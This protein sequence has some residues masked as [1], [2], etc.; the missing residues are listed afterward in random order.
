MS[1]QTTAKVM[2]VEDDQG[3]R[4]QL[5]WALSDYQVFLA[6]DR[7]SAL[8]LLRKEEPNVVILD[9]GLPP[10]RDGATE[11]LAVLRAVLAFRPT[12]KVI[13]ASGNEDRRNALE[14]ISLGAYDFYP[15]PVDQEV[16]KIIIDRAWNSHQLEEEVRHLRETESRAP[17]RGLIANSPEML[18]TCRM[19]ERVASSDVSVMITGESGTGKDVLANAIHQASA[20][21]SRPFVAINCAAIPENLLESELFGHEKGAFTGAIRQVIGKIEQADGGTLFLDEIGDMPV[22]LQAKLLRFLQDKKIVRVGGRVPIDVNLRVISATNQDL[23]TMMR[24][25]RFREDLFYRL[26][27][28]GLAVPPLR[29]RP[30]DAVLIAHFLLKHLRAD[31]DRDVKGFS[32]EALLRIDQ[33][34]WPG[35]VRELENRIKR[36]IVLTNEKYIGIEDLDLTVESATDGTEETSLHRAREMAERKAIGR[37]LALADNNISEAARLLGV[38]RPTLYDLIKSLDIP[39][40]E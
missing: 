15:K 32:P 38:T 9:L 8:A 27:E 11:G 6:E 10:D 3:L 24:D 13:V 4:T 21:K 14:A 20:R 26:N 2:I 18:K 28:V 29:D 33:Y 5:R 12:I 25:G 35:N 16:L 7:P 30:G 19:A 17:F 22:A 37:A 23:R 40:G 36:A 34:S 1:E 39:R 31:L